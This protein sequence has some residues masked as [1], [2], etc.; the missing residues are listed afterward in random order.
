MQLLISR[1]ER[2]EGLWRGSSTPSSGCS[3]GDD[4]GSMA[5]GVRNLISTQVALDREQAQ[6]ERLCGNLL[7][8]ASM[9]GAPR[10]LIS[11]QVSASNAPTPRRLDSK[12]DRQGPRPPKWTRLYSS[13]SRGEGGERDRA[14]TP[15][16]RQRARPRP[17]AP[18]IC[19][20]ASALMLP[21]RL[22]QPWPPLPARARRG[23]RAPRR[24]P[25]SRSRRR[26]RP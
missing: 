11:T 5:W 15:S 26:P 22:H 17:R 10:I 19:P 13:F 24:R 9:H 8:V 1:G 2:T 23:T 16:P 18:R 12:S 6:S 3:Y 21:S 20:S 7:N 25:T 4:V 14:S